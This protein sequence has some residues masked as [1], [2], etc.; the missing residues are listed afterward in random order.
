MIRNQILSNETVQPNTKELET[1]KATFPQFFD[2]SGQFLQD[3]F[4]EMLKSI[5]F[6]TN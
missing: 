3:R 4:N 6:E 5:G 1:L 2:E